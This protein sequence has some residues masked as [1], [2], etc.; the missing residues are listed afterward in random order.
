MT[1]LL[2]NRFLITGRSLFQPMDRSCAQCFGLGDNPSCN[3]RCGS[4]TETDTDG[5]VSFSNNDSNNNMNTDV[6]TNFGADI[7]NN[8]NHR[9]RR[10]GTV[11]RINSELDSFGTS[12][13]NTTRDFASAFTFTPSCKNICNADRSNSSDRDVTIHRNTGSFIELRTTATT[14]ATTCS[15]NNEI[16]KINIPF[17]GTVTK[18]TNGAITGTV[19]KTITES[20]SGVITMTRTITGVITG[21][22]TNPTSGQATGTFTGTVT[23]TDTETVTRIVTGSFT[24]KFTRTSEEVVNRAITGTV[25]GTITF[26]ISD[27][28]GSCNACGTG[29]ISGTGDARFC[30]ACDPCGNHPC[31]TTIGTTGPET[32]HCTY[33]EKKYKLGLCKCEKKPDCCN[34]VFEFKCEDLQKYCIT[35]TVECLFDDP[36]EELDCISVIYNVSVYPYIENCKI[37]GFCY[38]LDAD[39]EERM[40]CSFSEGKILIAKSITVKTCKEAFELT[41]CELK[42]MCFRLPENCDCYGIDHEI[43]SIEFCVLLIDSDDV[44]K[45]NYGAGS[46]R[47]NNCEHCF[48]TNDSVYTTGELRK[49]KLNYTNS[50]VNNRR[51]KTTTPRTNNGGCTS[52]RG[53]KK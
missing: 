28:S 32:G 6:I 51:I 31:P 8:L 44:N 11:G 33:E 24:G 36:K 35:K 9:R 25:T 43:K 29:T 47:K 53:K 27:A 22:V 18:T 34:E 37:V 2:N 3:I 40:D 50:N 38:N 21:T 52:C 41:R 20:R 13:R 26:V 23:D 7:T 14:T 15:V 4:T 5:S 16:G 42:K 19:T 10:C 48:T 45:Y 39:C 49:N 46:R 17:T 12:N 30:W 1:S